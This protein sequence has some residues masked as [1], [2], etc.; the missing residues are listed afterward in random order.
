[1]TLLWPYGRLVVRVAQPHAAATLDKASER[2]HNEH[3]HAHNSSSRT[4]ARTVLALATIALSSL[5][6]CG[7]GSG[8]S[9]SPAS[10]AKSACAKSTPKP[11]ELAVAD[12][13]KKSDL[14]A[15]RF[16]MAVGTDSALD[17]DGMR[18]LQDNGP[19]YLYPTDPA[20]QAKVKGQ[21]I[22]MGSFTT[23]LVAKKAEKADASSA[24]ITLSG[25]YVTGEHDGQ[26]GPV[27]TYSFTCNADS[28]SW[29]L[30]NSTEEKS[31]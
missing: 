11:I 29:R 3:M 10:A 13:L 14:V 15:Q 4:A 7:G 26:K 30:A 22:S 25:H 1:M 18:A 17:D 2:C 23:M 19:T 8:S 20:Q 9:S 5:A 6:A 16:L 28:A 31:S 24:T 12:Y 21:L 27:R